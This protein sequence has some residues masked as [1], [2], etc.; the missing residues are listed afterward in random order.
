MAST[1][2]SLRAEINNALSLHVKI[3]SGFDASAEDAQGR[4]ALE[5]ASLVKLGLTPIE[6]IRAATT[7]CS[8]TYG[9][10]GFRG[11]HREE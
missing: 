5:L 7:T 3:A 2:Q 9:M 8:R 6:A 11:V 1:M 4:N 10:A